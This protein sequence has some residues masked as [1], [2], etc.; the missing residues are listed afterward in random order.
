MEN[1]Q[2]TEAAGFPGNTEDTSIFDDLKPLPVLY[3]DRAIY[4]LAFL[5]STLFGSVLM[6]MNL[7]NTESKKGI[8]QVLAF[9]ILFTAGQIWLSNNLPGTNS[10]GGFLMNIVGAAILRYVFWN[11]YIGKNTPYTKRSVVVPSIIGI[12]IVAFLLFVI[13]SAK[14]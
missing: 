10:G 1:T 6:A 9:G 12:V 13:I 7:K 14:G 8:W 3:S 4:T 11:K 5:F 2:I